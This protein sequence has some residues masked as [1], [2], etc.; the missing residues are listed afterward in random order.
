MA[1][2]YDNDWNCDEHED[3]VCGC[4]IALGEMQLRRGVLC[5]VDAQGRLYITA[6]RKSDVLLARRLVA[7]VANAARSTQDLLVADLV[8]IREKP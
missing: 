8:S 4:G 1:G 2:L 3:S 7:A 5:S 6:P